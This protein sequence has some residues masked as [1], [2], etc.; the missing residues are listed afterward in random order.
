MPITTSAAK[1]LR[2][3]SRRQLVNNVVKA[4]IKQALKTAK[5]TVNPTSLAKAYSR[6]DRAAKKGIIHPNKAARLKS[7]LARFVN[8]NKTKPAL[9]TA[10]SSKKPTGKKRSP[11][12]PKSKS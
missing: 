12:T 7:R 11:K 9:A 1:A 2:R 10:K 3:S 5:V 4:K 6:L 8:Q